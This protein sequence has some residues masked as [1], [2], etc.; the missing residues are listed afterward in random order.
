MLRVAALCVRRG[1]AAFAVLLGRQVL[2]TRRGRWRERLRVVVGV[3]RVALGHD[4]GGDG[5]RSAA[6]RVVA[7]AHVCAAWRGWRCE[8]SVAIRSVAVKTSK[9]RG[10]GLLKQNWLLIPKV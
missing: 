10:L 7:V 5:L 8:V 3:T 6:G 9:R 1:R 4:D 2:A